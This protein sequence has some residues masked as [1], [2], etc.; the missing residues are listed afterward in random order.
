[1]SA[2]SLGSSRSLHRF[3]LATAGATYL[4]LIAGGLVWATGSALACPDWPLCYGQLFPR[5]VGGVLFEH[6]HRLI[7]ATV[8]TLTAVLAF[9]L[10]PLGGLLRRLGLLALGLVLAQALLGGLTVLLHLPLLVRVAH[11]ATSQAFFCT[12]LGIAFATRPSAP[13]PLTSRVPVA[14]RR[15]VGVAALAVYLQLILGAFVR[16]TGSGLACKTSVL[17]CD[18]AFWP[19]AATAAGPVGAAEIISLHRYAALLVAALVIASTVR[20]LPF[21]R[22]PERRLDRRLAIASHLLVLLQIG[23]G[24]A[25]VL[26]Y[27]GVATVTAHLGVGALLFGD[28]ASLYFALGDRVS[29]AQPA[30]APL[31]LPT[32][33]ELG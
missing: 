25:S 5:M 26:T 28:L 18:G 4:L 14:A 10:W 20:A 31:A 24:A 12:I 32:T 29:L 16:H 8:A 2:T 15:F 23:L 11:L 1:M 27:L 9:R 21:L 30:E 3:A 17:L 7:A 19:T 6:S 33:A 22:A 13:A